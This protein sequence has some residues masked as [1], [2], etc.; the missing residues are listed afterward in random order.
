MQVFTRLA[1]QPIAQNPQ[2][3]HH[4]PHFQFL[5]I[6]LVR[7][8]I[9]LVAESLQFKVTQAY[10]IVPLNFVIIGVRDLVCCY[11]VILSLSFFEIFHKFT[12]VPNSRLQVPIP[13]SCLYPI[14]VLEKIKIFHYF[15][16]LFAFMFIFLQIEA[17]YCSIIY[18]CLHLL[19]SPPNLSIILLL[20]AIPILILFIHY[21]KLNPQKPL[22]TILSLTILITHSFALL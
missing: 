1:I 7:E 3:H 22:P 6:L 16:F 13:W 4:P 8:Q 15:T 9:K 10:C 12:L 2:I 17:I 19:L 14:F 11:R 21:Q 20:I 18:S 5:E